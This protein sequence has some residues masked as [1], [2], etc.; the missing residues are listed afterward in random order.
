MPG[1]RFSIMKRILLILQ[2]ATLAIV[3]GACASGVSLEDVNATAQHL[4][5]TGI[6]LT[7]TAMPTNTL[8]PS[9]TSE[10]SAT[11]T[12]VP[13]ETS[14]AAPTSTAT[15]APT[16]T[17]Y[18]LLMPTNFGTAQADKADKN[19]PLA[20]QNATGETVEFYLL[21]PIYQ[22]YRINNGMTIILPEATYSFRYWAGNQGP[23]SGSFS[24]TNGDKHVLTLYDDKYHFATP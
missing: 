5:S 13:S 21:S 23:I 3:L 15:F 19:A 6:A 9:A 11:A 20:I 12:L 2:A 24:I 7:L 8:A 1:F 22:E 17:P 4:A 18:G 14:T 10:P 16:W